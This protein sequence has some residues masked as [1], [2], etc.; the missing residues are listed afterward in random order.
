MSS[1]YTPPPNLSA[2][3]SA[4]IECRHIGREQQP[5]LVIDDF[6]NNPDWLV[7]RASEAPFKPDPGLFPGHRTP[8]PSVYTDALERALPPLLAKVF[9]TRPGDITRVESSYSLVTQTPASL[10]PLQRIPH[11]DSRH[12]R[13]LASIYFLCNRLNE[14]Y[15][16]TA[17]YRHR[18]TGF[19]SI[20]EERFKRY[21][22][23]LEAD[24]QQVGLPA[25]DYIYSDT[26]V[27]EKI[28]EIPARYNRL[29]LY[30]CT[31]LHSGVIRPGFDFSQ[32]PTNARLSINSFL[33][34]R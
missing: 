31:S 27:F 6:L 24:A 17:F 28:A 2:N 11:F 13:E 29:V 10:K 3:P 34:S 30:P 14:Q 26:K 22:Q 12:P 7:K 5:V 1:I 15:G 16:G 33:V 9:D 18:S 32:E 21:M 4:H 20:T 23:A 25:A 8:A 19:E